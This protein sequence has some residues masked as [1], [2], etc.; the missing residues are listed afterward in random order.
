MVSVIKIVDT[1]IERIVPIAMKLKPWQHPNGTYYALIQSDGKTRR[2]SLHTK[3]KVQ[4][5]R[6]FQLF[7]NNYLDH[8]ESVI[9]SKF[10]G[11]VD[12]FLALKSA[13]TGPETFTLYEVALNKAKACWGDI[14]VSH[15]SSR[16]M[17]RLIVDMVKSGLA[18]ATVNKNYRHVKA[19]IR[20]AFEWEYC[21]RFKFPAPMKEKKIPRFMT[22]EQLQKL[23]STIDDQEFYD[24]CLF[25]GYTGLRSGE[26]LRLKWKHIDSP[27]GFIMVSADQK[28]A[29]ESRIPINTNARA[30]LDRCR[31]R[32]GE[33]VFRFQ[34]LTWVS[35]KFRKYLIK[36]G[37]DKFRFHDLRHTFASH[38]A[39]GGEDIKT[40]QEL[41]RHK[42]ITST[43]VYANLSPEHLRR[44]SERLNYGPLPIG[45]K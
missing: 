33:K 9:E 40:I 10:F 13:K 2:K 29:I 11:F 24:F 43:L 31:E 27:E 28:N 12:E 4:A 37:L 7:K 32:G 39:M 5:N 15:I 20:Q 45:K 8:S 21:K 26:I 18:P 30:I 23:M 38:L 36:V 17:D 34:T 14:F 1:K 44:A 6:R 35:Q 19:A 22:V 25:S 41:M 16:L 3:D 42:S